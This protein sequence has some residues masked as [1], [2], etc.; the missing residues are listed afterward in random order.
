MWFW[1]LNNEMINQT[2]Q[3]FP[4]YHLLIYEK[5][6]N[7]PLE[8]SKKIYD[9]CRLPWSSEVEYLISGGLATSV[10]G[11]LANHPMAT[12]E[13]WKQQLA[14]E[15]VDLVNLVLADSYMKSWWEA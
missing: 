14:S 1:R 10:W 4:N 15:Y 2:C 3:R 12:A 9:F 6:V 11:P 7:E 8:L 5:I 13:A